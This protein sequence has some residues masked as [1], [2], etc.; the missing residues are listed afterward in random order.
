MKGVGP[1]RAELLKKEL[2]IYTF[3][4]LLHHFPF[5]HVDRTKVNLIS[6]ITPST[7]FIQL[8]GIVGNF[9]II[10]ARN[11]RRAVAL[12][13]DK[14]GIIELAWFQSVNWI[15]KTI[16]P[17]SSYL[18]YGRVGF[19]QGKPQI[20]HPEMEI[21]TKEISEG[22][23]FL[24]PVYPTTEKLKAKGLGGKQI[25][26]LTSVLVNQLLEKN[27]PENLPGHLLKE[28]KFVNR[29][30]A[31][32]QIHFPQNL[33]EYDEAVKRLKFEELFISQ[34]RI[35]MLRSK[36]QRY[37]KGVVF[38]KVGDVF[39]TFYK[40]YIPFKLT[41]AQKRVMKEIRADT[42]KG[43]QMNRLLQGDE[44]S[45]KTIVAVLTM[46]LAV[47][48]GFQA[49]LMAPTEILAKQ[50]YANINAL[51]DKLSIPVKL[52]TGSTKAAE[53]KKI[54][55]ELDDGTIKILIGTHAV[56]EDNVQFNKLGLVVID[57]QH[58]FGVAQRAK[59]WEKAS[60]APHVLVM[61]ATPFQ[62]HWQ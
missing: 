53:R 13:K 34:L 43:T 35:G 48:N 49:C 24:E 23:N 9:E 4:D 26:K 37:S 12:L 41:G 25:G 39:N 1:Q 56:I 44:G 2:G 19:Y 29:F 3:H 21:L 61:T 8:A 60:V 62:E 52:L 11:T 28:L 33:N 36:R 32:T 20:V 14:S 5:R 30:F 17:G 18:V 16:E 7:D 45:G 47:D 15:E 10:G 38:D 46:L 54:L 31:F 22:K 40:E 57:E 27:I 50:H 42:A 58:R 55:A 6:D 51:L 59:L